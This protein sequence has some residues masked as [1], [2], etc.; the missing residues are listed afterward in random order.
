MTEYKIAPYHPLDDTTVKSLLS[1]P[2]F[3][4]VEGVFNIRDFGAGMPVAAHGDANHARRVK[5]LVLF[6]SGEFGRI[7]D[8]GIQQFR[9]LG[10]R[11]VYDLRSDS[12]VAKYQS[13][14]SIDGVDV[15]RAP[16]VQGGWEPDQ[17]A[18]RLKEFEDD[19]L[20]A[21]LRSYSKILD[22]GTPALEQVLLHLRDHPDVPCLIHCTAGK[23]RT[24]VFAAVILTLLGARDEDIAADY[25]L[26]KV[27]MQP[28]LPA[29][30]LRF[31]KEDAFREN[32]PGLLKMG[33]ASSQTMLA[34][35]EHIRREH[36]G[37]EEYLKKHTSLTSDDFERIRSHFLV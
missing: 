4:Q 25:A 22:C 21:F 24:G 15:V 1:A 30:A 35:L 32:W 14:K 27:G 17:V 10:I 28:V 12:E 29:L 13:D 34:F 3:V 9:A 26:T 36:G 23:D 6:R 18:L 7:T 20:G 16:I 19:Q 33:S 31:Q 37:V 11:K 2:P 8:R 5:P